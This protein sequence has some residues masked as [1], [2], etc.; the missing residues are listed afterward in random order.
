MNGPVL[1]G[2]HAAAG[3]DGDE[4]VRSLI[5]LLSDSSALATGDVVGW[6][7]PDD[8]SD[9]GHLVLANGLDVSVIQK[10]GGLQVSL[11]VLSDDP[12]R[13][14]TIGTVVDTRI[15]AERFRRVDGDEALRCLVDILGRWSEEASRA[16]PLV[17]PLTDGPS[18]ERYVLRSAPFGRMS[19]AALAD[20]TVCALASGGADEMGGAPAIA[21]DHATDHSDC[22]IVVETSPDERWRFDARTDEMLAGRIG[23]SLTIRMRSFSPGPPEAEFMPMESLSWHEDAPQTAEIM[24]RLGAMGIDWNPTLEKLETCA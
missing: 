15:D 22:R 9:T 10:A 17:R 1:V 4:A 11:Y 24:R 7:G 6:S 8:G 16:V 3:D 13:N 18:H 19:A 23:A 12:T 5:T 14:R 21:I 2:V 20:V